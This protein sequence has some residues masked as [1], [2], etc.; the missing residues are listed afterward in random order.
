[1][2]ANEAIEPLRRDKTI[3]SSLE[4]EYSYPGN[5]GDTDLAEIFIVAAVHPGRAT[6]VTRTTHRKCGR[7]WRHRSVSTLARQRR[8]A[9]A[10]GALSERMQEIEVRS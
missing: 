1:M 8:E 2:L 9:G 10:S 6:G 3:G 4:A 5:P 7:C